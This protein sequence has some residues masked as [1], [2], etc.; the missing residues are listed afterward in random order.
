VE[1]LELPDAGHVPW[2]DRPDVID[3]VV[4]F[5]DAASG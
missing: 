2:L 5:L 1:L 4:S 3:Y